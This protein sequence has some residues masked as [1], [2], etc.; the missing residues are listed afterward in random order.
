MDEGEQARAERE[1]DAKDRDKG[2]TRWARIRLKG[3]L[4]PP[5]AWQRTVTAARG[6]K[7][8]IEPLHHAELNDVED[9]YGNIDEGAMRW[10]QS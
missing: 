8:T 6:Q 5:N 9:W 4:L 2:K 7:W 3:F 10:P 1:V